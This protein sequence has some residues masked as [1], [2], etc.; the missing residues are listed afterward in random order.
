MASPTSSSK[1][2]FALLSRTA[3]MAMFPQECSQPFRP[4]N[5]PMQRRGQAKA[6]HGATSNMRISA[7]LA[8]LAVREIRI[9]RVLLDIGFDERALG[10]HLQSPGAHLIQ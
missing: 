3:A 5:P 8:A 10:D 2:L 6:V 7:C 4:A 1:R 9:F